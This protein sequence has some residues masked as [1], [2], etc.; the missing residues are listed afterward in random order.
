MKYKNWKKCH[1]LASWYKQK[2]C[3]IYKSIN[4]KKSECT[5]WRQ[6]TQDH[7]LK[8]LNALY[9]TGLQIRKKT[10]DQE[11]LHRSCHLVKQFLVFVR[12]RCTLHLL[13]KTFVF[14]STLC[15]LQHILQ[16]RL[17]A[18]SEDG[19]ELLL[20]QDLL[21]EHLHRQAQASVG[22][23]LTGRKVGRSGAL[24]WNCGVE[25]YCLRC[26]WKVMKLFTTA[27]Q[28]NE[29]RVFSTTL[30]ILSK[31]CRMQSADSIYPHQA[32]QNCSCQTAV[33]S[34]LGW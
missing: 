23:V 16:F 19:A 15:F 26:S 6:M 3:D 31:R 20:E 25:R 27:C 33:A 21:G 10:T 12:H 9:N 30:R 7:I 14:W 17:S 13:H 34:Q 18:S 4:K 29:R 22:R 32:S 1:F 2:K 5:F 28:C 11:L 24:L 8:K